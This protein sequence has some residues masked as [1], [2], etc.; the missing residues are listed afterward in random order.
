MTNA[1]DFLLRLALDRGLVTAAA[2][3]AVR[4]TGSAGSTEELVASGALDRQALA[5]AVAEEFGL[6]FVDV[7]GWRIPADALRGLP[8]SFAVRHK[9]CPLALSDGVLQVAVPDPLDLSVVDA[10]GH[11]AGHPVKLCVAPAEDLRRLVARHYGSGVG[12]TLS[13]EPGDAM[14]ATAA[15]SAAMPADDAP[16]IRTVHEIIREAVRRRAS[17]IHL[18]PLAR[19]LRVRYR[20]DGRLVEAVSPPRHLQLALISRVKLMA[21]ISIAE[22]RVPQDGRIHVDLAGRTVDLRVA[23]LPTSQGESVVLRLLDPEGVC[24]GLADLGLEAEDEARFT[25][26]LGSPD[27]IVLVT[28]PTGSGK[29]TTLHASLHHLNRT[30]RKIITVEDPIEYRLPGINQVPVRPEVGMTFAAAL[31]AML[32]QAPNVVMVGEIRDRETADIAINASLTGHL[33]FSTLH[34]NDAVGAVTRLIDIGARPFLVAAALRATVAQ[35]LV[36]RICPHC[37]QASPATP[38]ER[39][40]LRTAAGPRGEIQ[41]MRGRGCA[42]CHGTGYLGRLGIFEMFFITDEARALVYR[43]APAA[44]LRARARL[45]GLR[46]MR[47]DGLRKVLAGWTTIEEVLAVAAGDGTPSDPDFSP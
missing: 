21:N 4:Q 20:V 32:R 15:E 5:R 43:R 13:H 18:E 47:E 41:L 2:V 29:T 39:R 28:G 1:E 45:D 37:R 9:V 12:E 27:G 44:Q 31:R 38:A 35:R 16:V 14:D 10:V 40:L 11:A 36:R 42:R 46:T 22:K 19:R 17:D 6:P 23:T 8:R 25:N 7:A 30:S 34:T 3:D 24:R 26:L 33:V